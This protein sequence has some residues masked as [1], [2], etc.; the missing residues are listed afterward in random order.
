MSRD[1]A[2]TLLWL[3]SGRAVRYPDLRLEQVQR[4]IPYLDQNG[5]EAEFM[6]QGPALRYGTEDCLYGGKICE[7]VVQATARELLVEAILRLESHGQIVLFHVHDE[8]IVETP[9]TNADEVAAVVRSE[10]TRVPGWAAGLP[11][12]CEVHVPTRYGK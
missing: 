6:P 2:T 10:M 11:I 12:D 5:H 1:G 9:A 3:P 7:N 4:T 8:L